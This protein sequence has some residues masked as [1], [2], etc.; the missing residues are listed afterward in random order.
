MLQVATAWNARLPVANLGGCGPIPLK[1]SMLA[2]VWSARIA[3][4]EPLR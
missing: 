1:N 3:I 4:D 2:V